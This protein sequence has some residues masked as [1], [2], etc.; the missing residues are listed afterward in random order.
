MRLVYIEIVRVLF[1]RAAL[2]GKE[3]KAPDLKDHQ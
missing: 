1:D 3:I 2:A